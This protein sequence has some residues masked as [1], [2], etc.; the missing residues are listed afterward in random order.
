MLTCFCVCVREVK[1]DKMLKDEK[2]NK[3]FHCSFEI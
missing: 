3:N 1:N 2:S